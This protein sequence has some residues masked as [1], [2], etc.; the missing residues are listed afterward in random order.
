MRADTQDR[1]I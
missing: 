1:P